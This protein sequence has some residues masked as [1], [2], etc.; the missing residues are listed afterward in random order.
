MIRSHGS[1][2]GPGS[3]A[4]AIA[5]SSVIGNVPMPSRCNLSDS[6]SG[7]AGSRPKFCL[8]LDLIADCGAG[9]ELVCWISDGAPRGPRKPQI[10]GEPPEQRVRIEQQ[11]HGLG[12]AIPNSSVYLPSAA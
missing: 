8:I 5:W 10:V 12:E 6:I 3:A 4:A 1:R 11:P 9:H 7:K 2:C